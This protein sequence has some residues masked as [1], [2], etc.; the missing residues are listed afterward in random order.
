MEDCW[1]AKVGERLLLPLLR[2]DFPM[3]ID[4]NFPIETIFHGCA[5]ISARIP[6]TCPLFRNWNLHW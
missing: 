1:L 3:L 6:A 5:L 4:I 2:I